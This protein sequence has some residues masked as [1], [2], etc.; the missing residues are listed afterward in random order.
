[1]Y[2]MRT[3][4][5]LIAASLTV[6]LLPRACPGGVP[7]L[8]LDAGN[9]LTLVAPLSNALPT[10]E[11][12]VAKFD[13]EHLCPACHGYW[14]RMRD[15][16]VCA[17][18]HHMNPMLNFG[19]ATLKEFERAGMLL[20]ARRK[21]PRCR[22]RSR[23]DCPICRGSNFMMSYGIS[24]VPLF[25][26]R[27]A[28]AN[29]IFSQ[30][31]DSSAPYMHVN[32]PLFKTAALC[33]ACKGDGKMMLREPNHGQYHHRLG[34]QMSRRVT[35]PVC[36]GDGVF[37]AYVDPEQLALQAS[38]DWLQYDSTHRARGEIAV[39][40]AFVSPDDYDATDRKR[41]KLVAAAF[42][43]ACKA[44]NWTGVSPCKTCNGD[45]LL[46]CPAKDCEGGW[47]IEETTIKKPVDRSS[48]TSSSSYTPCQSSSTR[49]GRNSS[50]SSSR[51]AM[52]NL[53]EVKVTTCTTCGGAEIIV[54]PT[55]RGMR[56]SVCKKCHGSGVNQKTG[57][58]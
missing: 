32:L 46:P 5:L 55:C 10:S 35:C 36:K 47:V 29:A 14:D 33:P 18:T 3:H 8:P 52:M 9:A 50:K 41:L 30:G 42:P 40:N 34:Q 24:F 22:A 2:A 13:E 1:M 19:A 56:A 26:N 23:S 7:L 39:G 48:S 38:R 28:N 51:K 25:E 54:C 27:N 20:S 43:G 16:P 49:I 12:E 37:R 17:G 15:C 57:R 44:C 45:G 58:P 6:G 31:R 4:A 53:H 21:C 11:E